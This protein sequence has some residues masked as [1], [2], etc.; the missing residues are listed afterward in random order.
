ML[1]FKTVRFFFLIVLI[2]LVTANFFFSL[3]WLPYVIL[4]VVFLSF[5]FYGSAFINSGFYLK[6]ICS[7]NTDKK[8]FAISFDDGP[9]EITPLILDIL[10]EY[11]VKAAFFLVGRRIEGNESTVKRIFDEGHI[12]GNHSYSHNFWFPMFSEKSIADELIKTEKLI[13]DISLKKVKFFRP[14]CGVTNPNIKKAVE[15]MNYYSIGWSLKSKDTVTGSSKK[16][17]ERLKRKVK[18]GDVILMHDN[19]IKICRTLKGFLDYAKRKNFE[20]VRLDA[21]LKI[22]AYA[23]QKSILQAA[24]R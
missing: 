24:G 12:A 8:H 20:V 3:G 18:A 22:M 15:K 1:K 6:T 16:I 5:I 21:L 2:T 17:E 4:V 23:E 11:D 10:K 9:T 19:D 13:E 7:G 14:P